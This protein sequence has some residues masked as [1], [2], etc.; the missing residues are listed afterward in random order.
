M[1]RRRSLKA[2]LASSARRGGVVEVG[3]FCSTEFEMSELAHRLVASGDERV[4][5]FCNNATKYP[6]VMNLYA[7]RARLL[8]LMQAQ[9]YEELQE[10]ILRIFSLLTSPPT[11]LKAKWHSLQFVRSLLRVLP[12][13]LRGSAPVQECIE[14]E[15]DLST[16][17]ILK[18]WP[19]DAGCF[20]TLPM[21]ITQSPC[22]GIRNVGMYRMQVLDKQT[23]AMHWHIHKTGAKHYAEY[24][25]RG[26]RMPVVVALGGDPLL[27]YCATAPLPEGVD[28]FLFAG[29]LRKH[30]VHMVKGITV[31]LEVPAEADFILEGYIDP[32]EEK[33][34]EGAFGD[35]TGFYS[36]PDFYPRFHIT[37]I[38]HRRDA[39][40]PATVVGVPPMEDAIIAEVTERIF[41][42][43]FRQTF[44]PELRRFHFPTAGVAHNLLFL[45]APAPYP[46]EREKLAHTVW[47]AGQMM[48][49]KYILWLPE[50]VRSYDD[51]LRLLACVTAKDFFFSEGVT[52][53]LEHA[54]SGGKGSK[55]LIDCMQHSVSVDTLVWKYGAEALKGAA[56]LWLGDQLILRVVV[57]EKDITAAE[58]ETYLQAHTMLDTVLVPRFWLFL[59]AGTPYTNPYQLLWLTL[60]N[61]DPLRDIW[62]FDG[63]T[64]T[65]AM[66]DARAKFA[67]NSSMRWPNVV[68][69]DD[70]IIALVDRKWDEYGLD[71]ERIPSPSLSLRSMLFN[72][73]SAEVY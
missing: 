63:D 61:T 26:E 11:S 16:L 40:Y 6:V 62:L 36:L 69:S 3:A 19:H 52:D 7:S 38:T 56:E 25:A 8:E 65:V 32:K 22:T 34:L 60:A 55:L 9:S 4:I 43:I 50:H 72:E 51:V 28:E 12:R 24:A 15:P 68:V 48:F 67:T 54:T 10:R 45:H 31:P 20:L 5:L 30:P 58:A 18:T 53:V 64:E 49:T 57:G 23:T 37:C 41:E 46:A 29:F 71:I 17:P 66:I 39:V 21:V 33:V 27:A 44:L 1:R 42:P 73:D 2:Y 59:D 13:P 35:H 14:R 47:S 70:A